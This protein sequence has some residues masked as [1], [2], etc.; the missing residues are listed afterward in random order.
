MADIDVTLK[1]DVGPLAKDAEKAAKG[2]EKLAQQEERL[3]KLTAA[4]RALGVSRDPKKIAQALR[5][6]DSL[7]KA[8][9]SRVAKALKASVTE[10]KQKAMASLKQKKLQE[11]AIAKALKQ[12]EARKKKLIQ[13]QKE[14]ITNSKKFA[15]TIGKAK[16]GNLIGLGAEFGGI[17][18]AAG[19][20]GAAIVA[21]GVSALIAATGV[22]ALTVKLTSMGLEA[23]RSRD[24]SAG[25]LKLF[26]NNDV[27]AISKLETIFDKIGLSAQVGT[28]QFV[29]FRKAGLSIG[30]SAAA[31][32]LAAD[33][34]AVTKSS[35]AGQEALDQIAKHAETLKSKLDGVKDPKLR[36]KA[37]DE[38]NTSLKKMAAQVGAVGDGTNAVQAAATTTEGALARLDKIKL[39]ALERIGDLVSPSLDRLANKVTNVIEK[40]VSSKKGQAAIESFGNTVGGI[41]DKIGNAIDWTAKNWDK[42]TSVVKVVGTGILVA[43]SP[44][45]VI[46]GLLGAAVVGLGVAWTA[47]TAAVGFAVGKIANLVGIVDRAIKG[48]IYY[49]VGAVPKW[50]EAGTNLVNGLIQGITGAA[51]KLVDAVGNMAKRAYERFANFFDMHSPSVKMK[52]AG[53]FIGK[54]T[55]GGLKAA[56][57]GVTTASEKLAAATAGPMIN[58]P[59]LG[60]DSA[61]L[62]VSGASLPVSPGADRQSA[63]GVSVVFSDGAIRIEISGAGL[64]E[65]A[66][67]RSARQEFQSAATMLLASQ[68][69]KNG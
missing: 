22:A 23:K 27:S 12:E 52:I 20:A 36:A 53:R 57:P 15:E 38:Y 49:V 56:I 11:S 19:I 40:F 69:S 14:S 37:I 6:G 34:K 21:V 35:S 13:G 64:D 68:G 25:L 39:R 30:E 32:K 8:E 61:P 62:P 66:L 1:Q 51:G 28:D 9:E 59:S 54:G 2:F 63:P 7:A 58:A 17:G 42:I 48:A 31:I 60:S 41:L 44:A 55:E 33:I 3:K 47:S 43:I 16:S 5:L 45:L 4:D 65:E 29:K 46:L 10:E 18:I 24:D 26:A 50:I 67:M